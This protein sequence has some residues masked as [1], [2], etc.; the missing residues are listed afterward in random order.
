MLILCIFFS[1]RFDGITIY[2]QTNFVYFHYKFNN[3]F[4]NTNIYNLVIY[5]HYNVYM[6]KII[7]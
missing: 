3:H 4:V 7:T 5:D 6:Y 1:L 2:S